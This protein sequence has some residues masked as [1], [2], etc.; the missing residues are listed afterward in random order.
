MKPLEEQAVTSLVWN[1]KGST[2]E[3]VIDPSALSQMDAVVHL[4]GENISTGL[5]GPLA[6]IGIRPWT[7]AKK[8]EI[9]DSRTIPTKA[10]AN[11]ISNSDKKIDFLVSGGI[12]AYGLDFIGEGVSAADETADISKV[13]GF[14]AEVSRQ[15]EASTE[16]AEKSGNRVIIMRSG[17]VLSTK[18]GAMA[19]LYPIFLLGGGGNVGSGQQYFSFIS[20]RDMARA[21]V[22]MLETAT[23]KGPV[24]VC[25]PGAC[26]NAEFT[27][28]M[29]KVLRRPTILPFP[30]FAVSLMFGEMGEEI[31]LGGTR[32][33]PKKLLESGFQFSHPTV[34][35][36]VQSAVDESI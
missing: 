13:E 6:P 7:D 21:I 24:N 9:M 1:P 12:G 22:H 32:A 36:A 10:L 25:A 23:L 31:L 30:S 19:K 8:K 14:L 17:V 5:S 35:K 3:E 28:A 11:A 29:G 20:G 34:Y 16:A 2:A 26:T 27:S 15:W 4:A 18:G 33:T